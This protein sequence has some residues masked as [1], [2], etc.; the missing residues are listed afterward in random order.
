[1]ATTFNTSGDWT[2]AIGDMKAEAPAAGD[3]VRIRVR[4]VTVTN[5]VLMDFDT[6]DD[7]A[8]FIRDLQLIANAY[9]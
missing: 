7:L 1:M 8:A 2:E 6:R 9:A 5:D 4:G 3:A